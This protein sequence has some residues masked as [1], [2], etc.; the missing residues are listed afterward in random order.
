MQRRR[1]AQLESSDSARPACPV[2]RPSAV[3]DGAS[4]AGILTST[5]GR[6]GLEAEIQR[7][8][9]ETL[10][11]ISRT[12][13]GLIEELERRREQLGHL[14]GE[15]R[16]GARASYNRLRERAELW[17]W[18]LEVQREAVGLRRHTGLG[19]YY[20]IPPRLDAGDR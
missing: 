18:Y 1:S 7:E 11:R 9:A 15:E 2:P 8:R 4:G 6:G 10:V 20:P 12:L 19:E 13:T 16:R 3:G 14:A 5:A 17:A